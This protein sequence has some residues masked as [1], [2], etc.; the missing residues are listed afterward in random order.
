[1]FAA[2]FG[3]PML[4]GP[5]KKLLKGLMDEDGKRRKSASQKAAYEAKRQTKYLKALVEQQRVIIAN[6]AALTQA[7][8]Q[9]AILQE[10]ANPPNHNN[11]TTRKSRCYLLYLLMY[12]YMIR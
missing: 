5:N 4:R 8:V 3:V 11:P 9:A 2:A 7:A 12:L 1:M 10:R 6:G